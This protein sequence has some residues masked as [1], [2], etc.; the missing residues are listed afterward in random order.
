MPEQMRF[1]GEV[2]FVTGGVS[3]IDE[4]GAHRVANGLPD[5]LAVAV[6]TASASSAEKAVRQ[7]VEHCGRIDVVFNNAGIAGAQLA[8][9]RAARRRLPEG[10][11][12]QRRRRFAQTAPDPAAMRAAMENSTPCPASRSPTTWPS[13][14]PTKPAALPATPCPSTAATALSSTGSRSVR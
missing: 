11:R 3:D 7:A 12:H 6:D 8:V 2:A 9:A 5:V 14:P 10:P 13:W 4:P 1:D